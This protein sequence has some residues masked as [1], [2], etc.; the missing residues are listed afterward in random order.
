[1]RLLL[2]ASVLLLLA[3]CAESVPPRDL[4]EA[5]STYSEAANS[6]AAQL[7]PDDLLTAKQQL[8]LAESLYAAHGDTI[9]T[10]DA[11]YIAVRRAKFAESTAR[12]VIAMRDKDQAD[13]DLQNNTNSQLRNAQ[14][15]IIS[16]Q[17]TLGAQ[18]VVLN[19]T[20]EDL[21]RERVAR[22]EAE[23]KAAEAMAD[24]QKIANVKK[25]DRGMIIT[26]PGGVFFETDKAELKAA[27]MVKLNQVGDALVKYSPESTMVVEGHT[28]SQGKP[29]YNKDLSRRRAESVATYLI[30]RG[31]ARDRI[32][33]TGAGA[34]RPVADNTSPDGR[35]QNRRVEI[36]VSPTASM[37]VS[38]TTAQ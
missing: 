19:K 12:T 34:D 17:Q 5:R 35:A 8:D 36:I 15:Q 18:Q 21:Q 10:R 3:A 9:E 29:E 32:T 1:M 7:K 20:A 11:A 28:D 22:M 26:L 2:P 16:Q 38:T 4:V 24:L 25:D 14:G 23:R 13:K 6:P 27:A 33:S 31:I 37:A 30:S